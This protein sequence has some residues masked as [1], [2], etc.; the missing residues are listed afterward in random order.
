[1]CTSLCGHVCSFLLGN[2]QEGDERDVGC[3]PSALLAVARQYPAWSYQFAV[4]LAVSGCPGASQRMAADPCG[5]D[6][7][8][9][10]ELLRWRS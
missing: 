1:M 5:A 10:P 3:V 9:A 7:C 2:M 8:G 6:P 4:R